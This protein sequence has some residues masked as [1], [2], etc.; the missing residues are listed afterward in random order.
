MAKSRKRINIGRRAKAI[1]MARIAAA[2]NKANEENVIETEIFDVP[3]P[4]VVQVNAEAF[5]ISW[6]KATEETGQQKYK[7]KLVSARETLS[8]KKSAAAK[9]A[10][11]TPPQV[12]KLEKPRRPNE[13]T[14]EKIRESL[15]ILESKT[16]ISGNVTSDQHPEG[17]KQFLKYVVV[18]RVIL[19]PLDG[20]TFVEATKFAVDLHW[21]QASESYRH[22][23]ARKWFEAWVNT[24]DIP[25][26]Q[27]GKH[28]KR[29]SILSDI[30][31]EER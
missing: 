24:G 27:Q 9:A 19:D 14:L 26:H 15:P 6:S 11:A 2:A 21:P 28:A 4:D 20:K 30:D 17:I 8:R 18:K 7:R 25:C 29:K 1:Q 12:E 16:V 31:V 23:A 5:P 10:V 13:A 22:R 3:T